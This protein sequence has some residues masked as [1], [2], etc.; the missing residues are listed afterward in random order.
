VAIGQRLA[1][2]AAE[3]RILARYIGLV[4]CTTAIQS[5]QS[6]GMAEALVNTFKR[7]YARVSAKP[8]AASVLRQSTLGSRIT[9]ACIR[10]STGLP[11]AARVQETAGEKATE[12][13]V[14]A[15]RRPHDG[16]AATEAARSSQSCRGR[17]A[18]RQPR[19]QP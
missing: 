12:D 1:Y 14:G 18:P 7:D 8:D 4:P 10:I 5:P 16:I 15:V 17:G 9:T 2:T 11:F 3:T 19:A 13:A 6:N